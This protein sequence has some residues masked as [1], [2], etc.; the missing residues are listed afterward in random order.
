MSGAIVK[1]LRDAKALRIQ[2]VALRGERPDAQSYPIDALGDCM[3]R[4]TRAIMERV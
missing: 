1:Q 4:A 3:A 2:P